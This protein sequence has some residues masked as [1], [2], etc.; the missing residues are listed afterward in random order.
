[1]TEPA[2]PSADAPSAGPVPPL[3][4][5]LAELC[6]RMG[7]LAAYHDLSGE[8]RRTAPDTARALLAAMGLAAG[9]EEAA[10]ETLAAIRANDAARP[11]PAWIVL[12]AGHAHEL[13]PS[14]P[15]AW[16][17][18]LEDGTRAEGGA[19]IPIRLPHL[20][21]G[22]HRLE[23]DGHAVALLCA[24]HTLPLPERGWGVTLPLYG[25]RI[26]ERGGLGDYADLKAAVE[27]LGA[28]GAGFVGV[29]PIH[30]GFP[31]DGGAISPY[32]P[33]SRRRF[34]IRHAA[35]AG[36]A[37]EPG[38]DLVDPAPAVAAR[39]AALRAEFAALDPAARAD[40][41]AW[42]AA[43]GEDLARFALHQAL[44]DE[45][46]SWWPI[47]PEALKD[48]EG[49]A[50]RA[51]AAAH[52]EAVAFHAWAQY[53]AEAQ[54]AAVRDAG[55]AA[56]MRH[57]L[58]LDLAVGTS[59]AGAEVWANPTLF[60]RGV[61]LGAPPDD[62]APQGQKW[63]LAPMIP[64]AL[65]AALFRPLAEILR[66][67]L[68]FAG[69]LRIDHVLGFDR[70]FW[71][72][73]QEGAA[74]A[75]VAMPKAALLAVARIEGARAGAVIVGED[76]G[77]IPDGLQADLV[78]SGL[79]GC[80]LAMFAPELPHWPE[81]AMGSFGT[82]DL[83]PWEGWK[84]GRDIDWHARLGHVTPE[85]AEAWR[86]RR[87]AEAADLQARAGGED[88]G[89]MHRWLAHAPAR[90]L[91]VQL[92]DLTGRAEQANL[93]GTVDS[94]PNWRRRVGVAPEAMG[95]LPAL[96]EAAEAMRAAGRG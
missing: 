48:P 92:E 81:A 4:P 67:Q 54:L 8:E 28:A 37:P 84:Q 41:E 60:A 72:P 83:A 50:A 53:R 40:F 66:A 55:A 57:G 46:G 58:Y 29:N 31:L 79:L 51:F 10:A 68:R 39:L 87:A 17:L 95:D 6:A 9:T 16:A 26:A 62:F 14:R 45:H 47:W 91:A 21:L 49:A 13:W 77:V 76:L 75:Y 88:A 42:R 32:S 93:P 94:H 38:G 59:P 22:I 12:E 11:L 19:E 73:E 82:H 24:P 7:V 18:E 74:G 44:S 25:L 70:A 56:G 27:S 78:A 43:E 2:A 71:V 1:M 86:A 35:V 34:D 36:E 23:V 65:E 80:R 33:S 69:V 15:G 5:A 64:A 63:G 30:A 96:R 61:S 85:A 3:P 90:L 52:P 20:P 89:A